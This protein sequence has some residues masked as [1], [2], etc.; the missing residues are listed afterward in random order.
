M[1]W[2]KVGLGTSKF[3]RENFL[4]IKLCQLTKYQNQNFTS[5]D[6]KES[7]YL[8]SSLGTQRCN[9]LQNLLSFN[10]FYKISNGQERKKEVKSEAQ[11]F[12]NLEDKR[13]FFRKTKSIFEF[14]RSFILIAIVDTSFNCHN[15]IPYIK[16]LMYTY[17]LPGI[18][19]P[20]LSR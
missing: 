5:P 12:D 3:F 4:N 16:N 15:K 7:V 20:N 19:Y 18:Q 13:I 14:F 1:K 9:K 10:F 8:K 2:N 6:T 17:F 11:R